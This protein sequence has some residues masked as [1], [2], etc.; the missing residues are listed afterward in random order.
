LNAAIERSATLIDPETLSTEELLTTLAQGSGQD[1]LGDLR[2]YI[3]GGSA[4]AADQPQTED[5]SMPRAG[6]AIPADSDSMKMLKNRVSH[7]GDKYF[8]KWSRREIDLRL[9]IELV[10]RLIDAGDIVA[11]TE[12]CNRTKDNLFAVMGKQSVARAYK[13]KGDLAEALNLLET[14][15]R[16]TYSIASAAERVVAMADYA[17]TEHVIGLH[18]DSLDSYLSVSILAAS[19]NRSEYKTVGHAAVSDYLLQAGMSRESREQLDRAIGAALEL[20]ANSAARDLAL[21]HI[22]LT[23]AQ[24]GLFEEAIRHS[25]QIIDP[26]ASVSAYHGIALEYESRENYA[27]ATEVIQKAFDASAVI[28]DKEKRRQLLSKIQ[29]ANSD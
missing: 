2:R 23:E 17:Y 15:S 3:L 11:A 16:N 19:L 20:P 4:R 13:R 6:A 14:A 26:F 10:N 25:E 24:M 12:L 28:S 5:N 8:D 27:M 7:S 21:R 22:V 29:L 1:T 18:E 9:Y